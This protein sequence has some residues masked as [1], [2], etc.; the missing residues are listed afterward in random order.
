MSVHFGPV[1]ILVWRPRL[2]RRGRP[3]LRLKAWSDAVSTNVVGAMHVCR[4]VL[5]SMLE[6]R[7]GKIIL[8]VGPGAEGP[9]VNLSGYSATQAALVRLAEPPKRSAIPTSRS[10]A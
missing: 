9:R 8:L 10:I 2:P 4:A 5:P 3:T 7:S 6:R 1:Q